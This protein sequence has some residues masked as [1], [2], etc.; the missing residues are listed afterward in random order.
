MNTKASFLALG[1]SYTIGT[2]VNES[3]RW[4]VQLTHRLR[5]IGVSI[6]N[7]TIIAENGW[8]T[9]DLGMALDEISPE[10]TY[11]LVSLLIGVN[12]Q[13]QHLNVDDYRAE[14][15]NLLQTSSKLARN[16]PRRVIVLSIPDWG[17]TPFAGGKDRQKINSEIEFF[18]I[19]NRGEAEAANALYV[20]IT[21]VSRLASENPS[22]IASDGLHPSGRMYNMWVELLVPH[23]LSALRGNQH[24]I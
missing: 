9:L 3:E 12:N 18:N 4:P 13:Y 23:A 10:S 5:D 17:V 7:P 1:D 2:Y 14:F 11:D 24:E 22:L 21:P 19:V 20:D 15:R 6:D 16:D 8:T